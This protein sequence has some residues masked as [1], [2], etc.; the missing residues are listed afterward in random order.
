M[1]SRSYEPLGNGIMMID[2]RI[3]CEE[4]GLGPMVF[5]YG[6]AFISVLH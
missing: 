3:R 5:L 2:H 4:K 6:L 1:F